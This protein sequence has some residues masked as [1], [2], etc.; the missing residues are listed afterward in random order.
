MVNRSSCAFELS[1]AVASGFPFGVELFPKRNRAG[2]MVP[3]SLVV[4]EFSG[5]YLV[6]RYGAAFGLCVGVVGGAVLSG[7]ED[8]RVQ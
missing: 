5:G 2:L 7:E 3:P 4:D 6:L 8:A 1:R